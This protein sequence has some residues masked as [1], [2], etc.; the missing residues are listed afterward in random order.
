MQK[1]VHRFFKFL[2]EQ[3]CLIEICAITISSPDPLFSDKPH[4][5]SPLTN[6][7]PVTPSEV[8]KLLSSLQNKSSPM[9]I[10]PTSLLKS[11]SD[12]FSPLIAYLANLSFSEGFF[13][14]NFGLHL[15]LHFSRS[16]DSIM[17]TQPTIDPYPASILFQKFLNDYFLP[18][19]F[20]MLTKISKF[21]P[22]PVGI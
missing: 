13:H 1:T 20:H 17:T 19:C 6:P 12:V 7:E 14:L 10:L 2:S 3:N 22:T 9:D 4:P 5:G 18:G 16:L 21:K 11:C 15:L 8:T